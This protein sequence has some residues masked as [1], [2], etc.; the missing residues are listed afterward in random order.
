MPCQMDSATAA[1]VGSADLLD[2]IACTCFQDRLPT[3][4]LST[5]TEDEKVNALQ[6]C[7][8]IWIVTKGSVIPRV[9]QVQ[10]LVA[11]LSQRDS[12]IIAG[13][14]TGKTLCFIWKK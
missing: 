3:D 6:S 2:Q 12:V 4:Y 7:L 10:A 1:V 5:L 11:M 9:F 14:G 8:S 13:T